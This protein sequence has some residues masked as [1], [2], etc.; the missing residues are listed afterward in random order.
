MITAIRP[1]AAELDCEGH[2]GIG[3]LD[4]KRFAETLSAL[5]SYVDSI[6]ESTE[7]PSM[8]PWLQDEVTDARL[9]SL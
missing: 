1:V 5:E 8:E 2:S 9:A 4:L 7:L 6:L 3:Q